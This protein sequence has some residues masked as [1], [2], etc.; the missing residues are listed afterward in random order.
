MLEI[1]PCHICSATSSLLTHLNWRNRSSGFRFLDHTA[2]ALEGPV[3]LL[4]RDG[5]GRRYAQ[6]LV[7]RFFAEDAFLLQSFAVR[8]RRAM[9]LDS[10]PEPF[11]PDFFKI[12]TAQ[13]LQPAEEVRPQFGGL[14]HQVFVL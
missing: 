14:L 8:T 1:M 9:Q 12:R 5:Q 2:N 6:D 13:G 3:D 11:A 7:V 4:P 10:D